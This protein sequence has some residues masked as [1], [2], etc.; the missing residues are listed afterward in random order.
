MR[1]VAQFAL[2]AA[3]WGLGVAYSV[4]AKLAT[5][6]SVPRPAGGGGS[7]AATEKFDKPLFFTLLREIGMTTS[8]VVA[9]L[10]R[11]PRIA[12]TGAELHD[13][14]AVGQERRFSADAGRSGAGTALLRSATPRRA[15]TCLQW[16]SVPRCGVF[17]VLLPVSVLDVAGSTTYFIGLSMVPASVAV[18]LGGSELVFNAAL[19]RLLLRRRLNCGAAAGVAGAVCGVLGVGASAMLNERDAGSGAPTAGAAG[20]ATVLLANLIFGLLNVTIEAVGRNTKLTSLQTNGSMGVFGVL[21]L[22]CVVL[23]VGSS[24]AG[25]DGGALENSGDT[26]YALLHSTAAAALAL[27]ILLV[28]VP[29]S[30]ALVRLIQSVSSLF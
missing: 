5:E 4:T 29:Y 14:L 19:S 16:A 22:A 24:V 1:R 9:A 8:L 10:Q 12:A 21:L 20:V 26:V 3:V 11:T 30:M 6:T 7:G 17:P 23:P 2:A 13:A 15:S 27:A 28:C 25:A 18:M